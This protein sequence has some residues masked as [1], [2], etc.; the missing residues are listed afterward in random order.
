MKTLL[1]LLLLIE[2]PPILGNDDLRVIDN[3]GRWKA[4]PKE[5]EMKVG[6]QNEYWQQ[7]E[8]NSRYTDLIKALGNFMDAMNEFARSFNLNRGQVWPLRESRALEHAKRQ[9]ETAW[10]HLYGLDS[11]V[12]PTKR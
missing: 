10:Q 12:S 4:M 2:V 6:R 9:L 8:L 7:Q 5:S 1:L 3:F 11:W